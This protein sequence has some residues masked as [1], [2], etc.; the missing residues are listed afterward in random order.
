VG[1]KAKIRIVK[2]GIQ[3]DTNIEVTSGLNKGDVVIVGPYT[4][5]TKD[6][7]SG[8]KVSLGKESNE[9]DKK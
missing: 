4:T 6:L 9:K 8:D 1:N 7:N 3:D 2:T 5:V